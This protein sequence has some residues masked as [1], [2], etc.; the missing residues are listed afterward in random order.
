M[1][2]QEMCLI[3]M[4]SLVSENEKQI[5]EK[6]WQKYRIILSYVL[7]MNNLCV[8]AIFYKLHIGGF[9]WVEETSQL[10]EEFIKTYTKDNDEG[11]FLEVDAKYPEE[12][13]ELHNGLNFL[14]E[15]MK[16]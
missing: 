12:L 5:H 15:R 16:I 11:V 6:L 7:G 10:C 2:S 1:F 14:S 8:W 13:H 9:E 3:V 4:L